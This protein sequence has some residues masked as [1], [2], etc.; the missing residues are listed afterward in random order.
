MKREINRSVCIGSYRIY[1]NA[2]QI[3]IGIG[4]VALHAGLQAL[5]IL[6]VGNITNKEKKQ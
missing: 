1:S 5:I 6:G 3:T 4:E 2:S